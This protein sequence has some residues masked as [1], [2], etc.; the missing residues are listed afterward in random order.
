M[1]IPQLNEEGW[2]I[3]AR[4]SDI[5]SK[6]LV[7]RLFSQEF[8]LFC[9][10][11]QRVCVLKNYCPH[12]GFPLSKG[13]V[14]DGQLQ[15]SYH[16]WCFNTEG[17]CTHIPG[18]EENEQKNS[19]SFKAQ[20]ILHRLIDGFV[21]VCLAPED[22]EFPDFD[23]LEDQNEVVLNYTVQANHYLII[24]NTLDPFH[25][26][27]IHAGIVRKTTNNSHRRTVKIE[28]TQTQHSVEAH[29]LDEGKQSGIISKLFGSDEDQAF[30]RYIHPGILQLEYKSRENTR[31]LIT[32]FLK[33]IDSETTEAFVRIQYPSLPLKADLVFKPLVMQLLK[34]VIRQDQ[35]VCEA[36]QKNLLSQ[37]KDHF[38]STPLDYMYRHL[39]EIIKTNG[40]ASPTQR[41]FDILL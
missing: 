38:I 11:K 13:K 31:L 32:S 21:W 2:Y 28:L 35:R 9:D 30:G 17:H 19:Y 5:K 34:M 15:C 26:P 16:G 25:T 27:Y 12:R 8:V 14:V 29:Y 23:L 6:P 3:L 39:R 41:S 7:K 24:E 33:P 22:T 37:Q 18:M 36:Q 10:N 40:K 1:S 20:P 4:I